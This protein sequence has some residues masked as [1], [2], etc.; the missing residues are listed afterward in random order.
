MPGPIYMDDATVRLHID[1]LVREIESAD[2][3]RGELKA[4]LAAV[5]AERDRLRVALVTAQG[6]LEDFINLHPNYD[7]ADKANDEATAVLRGDTS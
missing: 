6:A 2:L 3:E 7:W 1:R 4:A 5:K